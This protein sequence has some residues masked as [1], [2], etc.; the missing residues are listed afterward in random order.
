MSSSSKDPP[1]PTVSRQ[2]DSDRELSIKLKPFDRI[3]FEER[4]STIIH[5][6]EEIDDS[7]DHYPLI[8]P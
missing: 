3:Y 2:K 8:T 1:S 5:G 4:L 6:H 7:E